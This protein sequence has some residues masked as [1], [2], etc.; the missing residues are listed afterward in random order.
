MADIDHIWSSDIALSASGDLLLAQGSEAGRQRVLRRLL[1][2]PG[3]L[4]FHL[5][6]GAGLPGQVGETTSVIGIEGI[7]RRQMFREDAVSQDPP[8][9]VKATPIIGGVTVHITYIDALTGRTANIGFT[10]ER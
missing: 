4:M 6:Y 7:V 3:E 2:N 1:T 10:A 8:P 9:T 5:D